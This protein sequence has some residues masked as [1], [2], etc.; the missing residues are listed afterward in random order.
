MAATAIDNINAVIAYL[1][2]Q[3]DVLED[4]VYEKLVKS[5]VRLLLFQLRKVTDM[6]AEAATEATS[7]MSDAPMNN[8]QLLLLRGAVDTALA[9]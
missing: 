8:D 4:D 2:S 9:R 1:R 3:H 6:S 5:Q 7:K